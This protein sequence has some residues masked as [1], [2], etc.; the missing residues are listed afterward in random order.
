VFARS[1]RQR[2]WY[3]SVAIDQ[4]LIFHMRNWFILLNT[5]CSSHTLRNVDW[6]ENCIGFELGRRWMGAT[7]TW[8]GWWEPQKSEEVF[9]S[10][11]YRKPS[12]NVVYWRAAIGC[13]YLLDVNADLLL[14]TQYVPQREHTLPDVHLFLRD[15]D[16]PRRE[17]KLDSLGCSQRGMSGLR[18]S[19]KWRLLSRVWK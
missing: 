13:D 8:Q 14:H 10:P 1:T 7:V 5:G 18:H 4:I 9:F 6:K 16:V 2:Y 11:R 12:V 17:P 15:Q 3:P 19:S